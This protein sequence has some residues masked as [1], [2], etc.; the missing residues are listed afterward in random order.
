M[1]VI[2]SLSTV[3]AQKDSL[4]TIKNDNSLITPR[5]PDP[6][7]LEKYKNDHDYNYNERP[8]PADNP[9]GRWIDWL[10]RK[11][12]SFF[13]S[14][15]YDNFWQYVIMAV[16]AGLV[17]YLLYK[18]KV[19]DYVFPSKGVRAS[20]DYV[21]GQENI[22]EINFE[23]AIGGALN[24][25]DFRLAIRLQYLRILKLLTTKELIHWK[26]NLTNQVYVQELEKYPYHPDFVQITRYFE[27]AWY[28]D[29]QVNESGFEEMKAFSDSFVKKIN[30]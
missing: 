4:K 28:G 5:Y 14:K 29:F 2:I 6:G 21:V 25:K 27:F 18:A 20:A 8:M 30:T 10:N 19:L 13:G 15:S 17:L 16:T 22:H 1:L 7:H 23:D 26:P 9:L 12:R 24:Q 11:I 3:S